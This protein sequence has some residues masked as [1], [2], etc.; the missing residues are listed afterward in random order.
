MTA[1]PRT[2]A[3]IVADEM[4]MPGSWGWIW[5]SHLNVTYDEEL[6]DMGIRESKSG[7]LKQLRQWLDQ[8]APGSE[9]FHD[10]FRIEQCEDGQGKHDCK[11]YVR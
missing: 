9:D 2:L 11:V 3:E 1:R 6:E 7:S 8:R 5:L 4:D 10:L